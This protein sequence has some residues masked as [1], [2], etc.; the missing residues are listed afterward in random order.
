MIKPRKQKSWSRNHPRRMPR[1]AIPKPSL[2]R[3]HRRT[4][5]RT[6][7]QNPSRLI[8]RASILAVRLARR[9]QDQAWAWGKT[10]LKIA[11]TADFRG[12][13]ANAPRLSM[14]PST[15]AQRIIPDQGPGKKPPAQIRAWCFWMITNSIGFSGDWHTENAPGFSGVVFA[16][17]A[18]RDE[19]NQ[20]RA[21]PLICHD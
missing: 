3:Q 4:K 21:K 17:T 2:I 19:G 7:Q 9:A 14:S 18:R 15:A 10:R 6:V 5:P 11:T 12:A 13:R 1:R 16:A 8:D 20:K